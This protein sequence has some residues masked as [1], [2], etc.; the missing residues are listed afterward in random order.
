MAVVPPTGRANFVWE[1]GCV[2][3]A[4]ASRPTHELPSQRYFYPI[5]EGMPDGLVGYDYASNPC[6]FA[7]VHYGGL[8][9]NPGDE[10]MRV[11]APQILARGRDRVGLVALT[12]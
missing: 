6:G 3:A 9:A 1:Q 7:S 5:F 11:R 12:V 4:Y 2:A 8:A 10:V